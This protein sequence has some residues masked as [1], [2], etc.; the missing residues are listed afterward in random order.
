[1][2]SYSY[3]APGTSYAPPAYGGHD[4]TA[5]MGRRVGAWIVDTV[6]VAAP[7]AALITSDL[8]YLEEGD[9]DGQ[10][11]VDFCEDYMDQTDGVCVDVGDRVYF[12]DGLPAAPW[13]VGLGVSLLFLVLLQG[14]KG[15]TPGKLLFGVRTVGEDGQAPGLGRALV[16]WLL[17]IID[18]LCLG[19]VGFI[20]ALTNRGHRRV[21]DMAAKTYVVGK[22]YAERPVVIPGVTPSYAAY[23]GPPGTPGPPGAPGAPG[24]GWGAPPP[25]PP[26]QP[27]QPTGQGAP[28][29]GAPPAWG[30]APR[31]ADEAPRPTGGPGTSVPGPAGSERA[32]FEPASETTAPEN[33]RPETTTPETAK[34]DTAEFETAAPETDTSERPEGE[35][36]PTQ[37]DATASQQSQIPGYDPQWDAARGTY[38]VWSAERGQWLG[39]DD[40]AKEW[41]PL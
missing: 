12:S 22:E 13:L 4:P 10:S 5:V 23:P 37:A 33:A 26:G 14:L 1:M 9:L 25:G 16:R 31:P 7:A 32:P 18:G 6:I 35:A 19:L 11:G 24:G 27:S 28:S 41:K 21:G 30:D 29:W 17:L 15:W 34:F 40:A 2:S 8:E 36:S 20:V 3:P 39:W 38:I